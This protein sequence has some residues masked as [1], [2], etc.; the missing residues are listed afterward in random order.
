MEV[1]LVSIVVLLVLALIAVAS[2][3][4]RVPALSRFELERR[5]KDGDRHANFELERLDVVGSM[6]GLFHFVELLLFVAIS[7]ILVFGVGWAGLLYLLFILVLYRIVAQS[8]PLTALGRRLST[9]FDR[10]LSK[11]L[12]DSKVFSRFF[13]LF[14]DQASAKGYKLSS[15]EELVDIIN[16]SSGVLSDEEKA[17]ILGGVDILTKTVEDIM[18]P[19]DSAQSVDY[20]TLLGP[21]VL[22]QLHKTGLSVFPVLD[23]DRVVGVLDIGTQFEL[24]QKNS[25]LAR[26]LMS[27][28]V[29]RVSRMQLLVGVIDEMVKERADIAIV[30]AN[31]DTFS[32]VL[33]LGDCLK[34]VLGKW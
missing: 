21:M 20:D 32:G 29:L 11:W 8:R 22:D 4:V 5:S 3:P 15:K 24:R 34:S 12:V 26:D 31:G 14:D 10:G 30:K 19:K 6:R 18:I 7:L 17:T 1:L 33:Y 27:E 28:N 16:R 23:G 9:R 13:A 2:I 25:L